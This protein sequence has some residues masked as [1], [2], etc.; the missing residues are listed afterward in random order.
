MR[1]PMTDDHTAPATKED[2]RMLMEEFGKMWQWK[3]QLEDRFVSVE[4]QIGQL[5]VGQRD[6]KDHFD[7]VAENIREDFRS[8]NRE[9]IEVIKDRQECHDQ[10]ITALEHSMGMVA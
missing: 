10:R 5:V 1:S 6:I 8:A 9:E 2:I 3:A 7:V 4:E